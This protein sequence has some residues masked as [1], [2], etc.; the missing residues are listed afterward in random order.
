MPGAKV[1]N[2]DEVD[3]NKGPFTLKT[4]DGESH[5]IDLVIKCTGLRV[6]NAAYK[7]GLGK[8]KTILKVDYRLIYYY[9][10]IF[11]YPM[12]FFLMGLY[13]FGHSL[14][15]HRREWFGLDKKYY[16]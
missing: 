8:C 1:T 12:R 9:I 5:Q 2:L 16:F 10:I 6:N 13:V 11:N 14:G 7:Q 4:T 15:N 3:D